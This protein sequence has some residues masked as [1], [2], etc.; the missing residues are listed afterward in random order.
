MRPKAVTRVRKLTFMMLALFSQSI[1]LELIDGHVIVHRP[2][3]EP[4]IRIGIRI[5]HIINYFTISKVS[6]S[7]AVGNEL[8]FDGYI[9]FE[10]VFLIA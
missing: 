4:P 2:E 10:H 9:V 1:Y 3:T 8:D 7:L 5:M 6:D